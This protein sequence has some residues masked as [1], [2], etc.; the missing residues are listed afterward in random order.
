MT[1]DKDENSLARLAIVLCVESLSA[2]VSQ[3]Y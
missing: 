3:E 2:V 1:H